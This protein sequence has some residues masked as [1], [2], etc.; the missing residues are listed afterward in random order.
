MTDPL[1][2][3]AH[4]EASKQPLQAYVAYDK[5]RDVEKLVAKINKQA[6]G[7]TF[8]KDGKPLLETLEGMKEELKGDKGPLACARDRLGTSL[9]AY[10][11]CLLGTLHREIWP[12]V[13]L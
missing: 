12:G 7:K 9:A 2:I 13:V 11:L 3:Q 6:M 5:P 10:A 8:K 1:G 4:S